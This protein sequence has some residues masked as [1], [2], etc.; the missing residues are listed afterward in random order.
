M[1]QLAAKK[2]NLTYRAI[3]TLTV[4]THPNTGMI[5]DKKLLISDPIYCEFDVNRDIDSSINT[6]YFKFHNLSNY[7]SSLINQDQFVYIKQERDESR[8]L[9]VSRIDFYAFYLGD[10][11]GKYALNKVRPT[12]FYDVAATQEEIIRES[13]IEV[14]DLD[15]NLIFTGI[16]T[17]ANTYRIE[18]STDVITEV[19]SDD[20]FLELGLS[21][22]VIP[23][24]T[25]RKA[26]ILSLAEEAGITKVN[27]GDFQGTFPNPWLINKGA[28]AMIDEMTGGLAFCDL[29]T[30][31]VLKMDETLANRFAYIELNS[32][33]GLLGTPRRTWGQLDGDIIF[34]P[35]VKL[36]MRVILDSRIDTRWNGT[37]KVLGLR[38][39]GSIGAGSAN[40][41]VTSVTLLTTP[42]AYLSSKI[43]TGE[44]MGGE[45][46]D[47]HT[48]EPT[49]SS[50]TA[51][52]SE[53]Q[54]EEEAPGLK[55]TVSGEKV[56]KMTVAGMDV[57]SV[58]N[59][60][61]KNHKAPD[62]Q[63]TSEIT[64][65]QAIDTPNCTGPQWPTAG[66]LAN[67]V[68]VCRIVQSIR[69]KHFK[70]G[71]FR[72]SSGW[73]SK[74]NNATLRGAVANSTHL[75][76]YALDF[77]LSAHKNTTVANFINK[78][79]KGFAYAM[80]SNG[81]VH[82]DTNQRVAGVPKPIEGWSDL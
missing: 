21:T 75:R 81:G 32:K 23:P 57:Y 65:R 28:F 33:S 77:H 13:G 15:N 82:Y 46:G 49:P 66:E 8:I 30:L 34:S 74:K 37:Y 24:G 7:T 3:L 10:K 47:G 76:G 6:G 14:G 31:N 40:R 71:S 38:H 45:D 43:L 52:S 61:K 79:Y 1:V 44:Y 11:N 78:N 63:I 51:T 55:A 5:E 12:K 68:R 39:Q 62:K 35:E 53:A 17:E 22:K 42:L 27:I 50:S 36:A 26:A 19:T 58:I 67:L 18:G 29:G 16:I 69:D 73:R 25:E 64:W 48:E 20:R 72:V 70:G 59:Y 4:E 56:S 80:M 54:A 9:N 41:A 2:W 60:I